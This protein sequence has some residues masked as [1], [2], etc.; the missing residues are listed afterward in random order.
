MATITRLRTRSQTQA[1][2]QIGLANRSPAT[3]TPDLDPV[4][5]SAIAVDG[6]SPPSTPSTPGRRTY[7]DVAAT[8]PSQPST[9]LMAA[10]SVHEDEQVRPRESPR[11]PVMALER[12]DEGPR[13]GEMEATIADGRSSRL[14]GTAVDDWAT[15]PLRRSASLESAL[16][17]VDG[18]VRFINQNRYLRLPV[19]SALP[20]A[21]E[22]EDDRVDRR[23]PAV[24]EAE[25]NLTSVQ[26]ATIVRRYENV[27]SSRQH[28]RDT[29]PQSSDEDRPRRDKGKGPDPRNWGNAH[30]DE[31]EAEL[32]FQRAVHESLAEHRGHRDQDRR[33]PVASGSRPRGYQG[34]PGDGDEDPDDPPPRRLPSEQPSH[35]SRLGQGRDSTPIDQIPPNSI[36]VPLDDL[37]TLLTI[38]RWDTII[39]MSITVV[40]RSLLVTPLVNHLNSLLLGGL[41]P[42]V[43]RVIRKMMTHTE[44]GMTM[45]ITRT[46]GIIGDLIVEGL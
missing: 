21:A 7:A 24:D 37:R 31:D 16:Q 46:I 41:L 18:R 6:A 17:S 30:L 34:H 27:R 39:M 25:R 28:A 3:S 10:D 15:I 45:T 35:R 19:F 44:V 5:A 23:D 2:A 14:D 1:A 40:H 12:R 9:P 33:G 11:E 13:S 43:A 26:R 32:D 36:L 8:P 22:P 29:E 20:V 42:V 38:E 4:D